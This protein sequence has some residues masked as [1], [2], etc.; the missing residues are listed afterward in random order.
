MNIVSKFTKVFKKKFRENCNWCGGGLAELWIII[1]FPSW[2]SATPNLLEN[3]AQ[4]TTKKKCTDKSYMAT[5]CWNEIVQFST[6]YFLFKKK[7]RILELVVT[8]F[9]TVVSVAY[10]C[11]RWLSMPI[12]ASFFPQFWEVATRDGCGLFW[13]S[14]IKKMNIQ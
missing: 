7:T 12:M 9:S 3:Y 4:T 6:N 8:K 10:I 11:H 13:F 1:F 2:N 5:E 14:Q